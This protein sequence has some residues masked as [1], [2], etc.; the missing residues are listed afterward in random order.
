M[1]APPS[2]RPH[3]GSRPISKRYGTF[4]PEGFRVY[5]F[6]PAYDAADQPQQICI[7]F[8]RMPGYVPAALV[9]LDDVE[10]LCD[11]LNRRPGLDRQAWSTLVG[12]S[13]FGDGG[14]SRLVY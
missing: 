14:E 11:K 8:Q 10:R 3:C 6:S 1:K 12:R 7:I 13:M 9:A 5:A 4:F 2:F